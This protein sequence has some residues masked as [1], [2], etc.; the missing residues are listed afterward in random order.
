MLAFLLLPVLTCGFFICYYS[1]PHFYKLHRYEGQQLYLKSAWLGLQCLFFALLVVAFLN[2]YVPPSIFGIPL[3]I[4]SFVVKLTSAIAIKKSS[5]IELTWL[6][7]IAT[8]MHAIAYIRV[9]VTNWAMN[10]FQEKEG[11][12][13]K[14]KLMSDVLSDSPLDSELLYSYI[15][16]Q[17][18]LIALSNRK[19]YVGQVVSM[20]E[21]NE[22]EGMDQ[23][24]SILP[25]ISGY[26]DKDNLTVNF[27]TQYESIDTDV[28]IKVTIRQELIES[29]SRFDFD[30]YQQFL[31]RKKEFIDK[32]ARVP[33]SKR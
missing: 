18:V 14:I 31:E 4:Y 15:N 13:P 20:G 10:Q 19:V 25:H 11:V 12:D 22:S 16:D 29:V 6:F 9:W 3:D 26:R 7:L 24:I 21:P 2:A 30:V 27:T 1:L 8:T 33:F 28:E 32:P 23:E 5:A 17:S